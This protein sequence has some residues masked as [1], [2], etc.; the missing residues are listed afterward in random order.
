VK[1]EQSFLSIPLGIV[2]SGQRGSC[3]SVTAAPLGPGPGRL[4]V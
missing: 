4:L 1:P 3:S 2:D